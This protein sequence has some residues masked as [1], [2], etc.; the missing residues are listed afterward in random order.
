MLRTITAVLCV[1]V[2]SLVAEAF[3]APTQHRIEVNLAPGGEIRIAD[4]VRVSGRDRYRFSLANWLRIEQLLVD[5]HPTDAE[6]QGPEYLVHLPDSNPHRLA[7]TLRGIVPARAGVQGEVVAM[8]SSSGAD[9]VYLPGYDAWIPM[10]QGTGL[11]YRLT[12]TTT[13][14]QLAVATGKLVEED[15][16]GDG[17]QASFVTARPG[18]AP[19]LFVGPYQIRER[20]REGWRLRTYFHAE[21][22]EFADAYL[23][24][25]DQYIERYQALIGDYPYDDFHI[26]SAPLPVGLGFPNLAYV[27]REVIPL[28]FMRSR[29]LAHEVLHNWWGNGVAVDYAGGNWS[30]GLTTYLADYALAADAGAAAAQ[31]MRIKW[32]RDYAALPAARDRPVTTFKSKQHQASQVI[33]YNKVAFIFHMLRNEIG[34]PAFD[35]GLRHFWNRHKYGTASWRDLQTA[36]EQAAGLGLD[37]FFVQWLQRGGAPRLSLGSHNVEPV[38][39]GFRTRIE[40]LQNVS[41]YRFKLPVLLV[42]EAQNRRHD[43]IIQ[44]NLTR[45]EFVTPARPRFVQLDPDNDI[46]RRLQRNETPPILRDVTLDPAAVVVIDSSQDDFVEL[47]QSLVTTM[48]DTEPGSGALAGAQQANRALLLVT[49]HDRLAGQLAQLGLAAPAEFS[50]AA[51]SAAVWTATRKGG[52]AVLVVSVADL[53]ALASLL[54]PLP[55]YGGQSYVLFDAGRAVSRGIWPLGR[56]ALYRDLDS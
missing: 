14:D 54:R 28:A 42:T 12:V 34:Q 8:G 13:G 52:T 7:F 36:F 47:A 15:S 51:H 27:G 46:F 18:P 41:G 53:A 2:V 24:S 10:E 21:L 1:T 11:V 45:V 43:I 32:L 19:T 9:G 40:I 16:S 30:E 33:G 29:S 56:G 38:A 22:T 25:A 39:E 17:Y 23:D 49:T 26:V 55:H 35:E 50:V 48:M 4:E 5:G 3:G 31:A 37:W 6:L 20:Q 44:D